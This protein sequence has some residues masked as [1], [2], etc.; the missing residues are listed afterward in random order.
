MTPLLPIAD[1]YD[2][3]R[4]TL[5]GEGGRMRVGQQIHRTPRASVAAIA[6]PNAGPRALSLA[7]KGHQVLVKY[8]GVQPF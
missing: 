2:F 6:A 1:K 7:L 8:P 4:R 5:L 3:M